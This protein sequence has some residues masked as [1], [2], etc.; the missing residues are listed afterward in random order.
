MRGKE[1][2]GTLRYRGF[3]RLA[4]HNVKTGT[5]EVARSLSRRRFAKSLR[6]FIPEITADDLLRAPAG[7]RAQAVLRDGSLVDDFLIERSG[8][9]VN[10]LNAPSPAATSAFE[11]AAHVVGLIEH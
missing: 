4:S 9:L 7:V 3:W 8:R 10:V 2:W 1:L 11:I 6:A 5:V